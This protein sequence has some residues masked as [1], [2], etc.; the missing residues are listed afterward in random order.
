VLP[1]AIG[2]IVIVAAAFGLT[3][4]FGGSSK[5]TPANTPTVST[6]PS[7]QLTPNTQGTPNA[8]PIIW[9]GME[10]T[11]VA[12]GVTVVETV[13]P[14]SNG[15]LA[16]LEPGDVLLGVNNHSV[17]SPAAVTSAIKGLHTG[18]HVTLEVN[19]GGAVLQLV[20]TLAAPPTP[21]P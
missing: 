13:R 16:G 11:S 19:N 15:D 10:I 14:N 1:L 7:P 9:L 6:L 8:R 20:A 21:Y 2:A 4:V 3:K 18:D 5:H 17:G 12:P